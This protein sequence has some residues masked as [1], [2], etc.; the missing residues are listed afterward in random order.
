MSLSP[1]QA[2]FPCQGSLWPKRVLTHS[3]LLSGKSLPSQKGVGIAGAVCVSGKLPPR[4]RRRLEFS[5]AWD[6]PRIMF[7]AKG[8][9]YYR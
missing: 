4:G 8:Q 3:V 5:L 9:V 7:G 2:F 1:E 6:M